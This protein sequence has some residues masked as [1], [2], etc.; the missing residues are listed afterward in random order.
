VPAHHWPLDG[1]QRTA[2]AE[3]L[4]PRKPVGR[5]AYSAA[6]KRRKEGLMAGCQRVALSSYMQIPVFRFKK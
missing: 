4:G 2:I 6:D 5:A 3:L 1:V